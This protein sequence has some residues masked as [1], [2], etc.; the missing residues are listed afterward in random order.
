VGQILTPWSKQLGAFVIGV[1]SRE[2]SSGIARS[3]GCDAVLVWGACDLPKEV[4]KLSG[5]RG[6]HIV[7]DGLGRETLTASLESL[8]ARGVLASIGSSTGDPPVSLSD[9]SV[10]GDARDRNRGVS[11]AR[12]GR[13]RGNGPWR[14][15]AFDLESLPIVGRRCSSCRPRER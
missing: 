4:E 15:Q 2:A 5:G 11:G 8:A 7:Y 9:A 12:G 10:S 6:A 14:H 3:H 13:V 1:V